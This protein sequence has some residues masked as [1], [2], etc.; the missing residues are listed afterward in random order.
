M[1][2][3]E[4]PTCPSGHSCVNGTIIENFNYFTGLQIN[5]RES[6][7]VENTLDHSSAIYKWVKPI[8][9]AASSLFSSNKYMNL[10]QGP[11]KD[12]THSMYF[13]GDMNR[14]EAMAQID[15]ILTDSWFNTSQ[16]QPMVYTDFKVAFY[17]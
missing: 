7:F 17:N 16:Q 8:T 1:S 14:E 10:G 9:Y 6:T 15:T 5:V 2:D 3:Y 11:D 12:Q 4:E 13:G